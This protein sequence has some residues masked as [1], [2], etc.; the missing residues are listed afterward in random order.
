MSD[1]TFETLSDYEFEQLARDLLQADLQV[2]LE[3]FMRGA[4]Q[5]ID[6][7][8][9]RD[10]SHGLVVQCKHYV[11]SGFNRLLRSFEVERAKIE[12]LR[13]DRYAI[14]T[15]V[16]L[17][18]ERK[19]KIVDLLSPFCQ[20]PGDVYGAEDLNGLL[21]QHSE[22]EQRHPKLWL[23]STAVLQR[24]LHAGV[25]SES[26]AQMEEIGDRMRLYVV[27]PSFRRAAEILDELRFCIV[28]GAPGIGKSTLAEMLLARYAKEGYEVYRIWEDVAEA[29]AIFDPDRPQIF[30]YDDFLGRTGLKQ[31]LEKN[32]DERLLRF[33]ASVRRSNSS[34]FVLTTREYILNQGREIYEG[35][36]DAQLDPATCVVDLEQYTPVIRAQILYNHLYFSDLPDAYISEMLRNRAYLKIIQHR[37]F[38]PRIVERMS[39]FLHMMGVAPEQFV[40]H[41]LANLDHPERIW[42]NA[43]H[44]HLSEYSRNLLLVLA[45]LPQYAQWEDL[46]R[47]FDSFHAARSAQY[48]QPRGA[49]DL[50]RAAKELDGSLIRSGRA[51][52]SVAF[53]FVNPSVADFLEAHLRD[54]ESDAAELAVS[55]VF[56]EQVAVLWDILRRR[57][58]GE[59]MISARTALAL[60]EAWVRLFEAAPLQRPRFDHRI[61]GAVR[62]LLPI[63]SLAPSVSAEVVSD[64]IQPLLLRAQRELVL[65]EADIPD[66][67]ELLKAVAGGRVPGAPVGGPMHMALIARIQRQLIFDDFTIEDFDAL[68]DVREETPDALPRGV[69]SALNRSLSTFIEGEV[70]GILQQDDPD[71]MLSMLDELEGVAQ[72]YEYDLDYQAERVRERA[73]E[74]SKRQ[75]RPPSPRLMPSMERPVDPN[76]EI[77]RM[78]DSLASRGE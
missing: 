10:E 25:F 67:A 59:A 27:N 47:A 68:G 44:E 26:T 36:R 14:V 48:G 38:S 69:L 49:Y 37:T 5:G 76:Q 13:P 21:R 71:H 12:R 23:T 31:K 16:P 18:P 55:A 52:H 1:Y 33:I 40:E 50:K 57:L 56:F 75:S 39:Q 58:S 60:L 46:E 6:L 19:E 64:R 8:Y 65:D 70:D 29:R 17:S 74:R 45:S 7:R 11:R 73:E 66:V 2:R 4:D 24:V 61:R 3:S 20:T 41:F 78:F 63:A 9:T 22:I 53:E 28:A 34:R 51:G 35:L 72:K 42:A 30:F 32:E 54:H 43:F 15:S 77:V 62:R